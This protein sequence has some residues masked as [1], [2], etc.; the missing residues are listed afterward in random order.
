LYI[1]TSGWNYADWKERFYPK[2]LKQSEWLRFLAREFDTTEI[3]NSFYRIPKKEYVERWAGLVP[4]RFRFSTKLWRGITQYKKLNDCRDE[5]ASFL[6]AFEL[7]PTRKRGPVLVQLPPSQG[8]DIDKLDRFL[9]DV[10]QVASP[11]RWKVAI[12]F[13]ND[14]WLCDTVYRLLDRYAAALCLHDMAGR[15]P[16]NEPNDASFVYVRR[17]GPQGDYRGSYSQRELRRDADNIRGW[18]GRRKTVFVYFNNDIQGYAI[19]NARQ[20]KKLLAES[21]GHDKRG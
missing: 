17:H 1:G 15:A 8:C 2:G 3:N 10:R 19:H 21:I 5:L 11:S 20:L 13:R 9:D 18:L 16:V 12:E 14:S 6:A 4:S 7:L